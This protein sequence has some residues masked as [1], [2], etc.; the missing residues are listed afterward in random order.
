MALF[1]IKSAV[2]VAALIVLYSAVNGLE[3]L[4]FPYQKE[5]LDI[6]Q[7]EGNFDV[8]NPVKY[9][10]GPD[11][12]L[13]INFD[14]EKAE[15]KGDYL[16]CDQEGK[17]YVSLGFFHQFDSNENAIQFVTTLFS[18]KQF[19]KIA[20]DDYIIPKLKLFVILRVFGE[21]TKGLQG[22]LKKVQERWFLPSPIFNEAFCKNL[23]GHQKEDF[24]IKE[25]EIQ[26]LK[27]NQNIVSRKSLF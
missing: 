24:E 22:C 15:Y 16:K 27:L 5:M 17:C 1:S 8:S 9:S 12:S 25:L 21:Q 3:Y 19:A 14:G 23:A 6:M 2:C 11:D 10:K 4:L 18:N 20:K 7:G 26:I 13:Q